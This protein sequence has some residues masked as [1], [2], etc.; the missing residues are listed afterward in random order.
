V[1]T[2]RGQ[3]FDITIEYGERW[4][5]VIEKSDWLSWEQRKS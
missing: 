5:S 2:Q 1:P 4:I 3:H